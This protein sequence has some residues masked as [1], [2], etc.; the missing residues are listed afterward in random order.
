MTLGPWD[1]FCQVETEN[2]E[3]LLVKLQALNFKNRISVCQRLLFFFAEPTF[4]SGFVPWQ[5]VL[6]VRKWQQQST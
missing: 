3:K 6:G 2:M 5:L 4:L 1:F